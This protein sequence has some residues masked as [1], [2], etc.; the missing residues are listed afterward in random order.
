[1]FNMNVIHVPAAL[2]DQVGRAGNDLPRRRFAPIL[3]AWAVD[4]GRPQ[5]YGFR[6][7]SPIADNLLGSGLVLR[8]VRPRR[9]FQWR[10]LDEDAFWPEAMDNGAAEIYE[11]TDAGALRGCKGVCEPLHGCRPIAG[12][13]VKHSIGAF[14]NVLQSRRVP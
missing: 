5:D 12:D 7:A 9:R 14:E 1:M 13:T 3:A 2:I 10:T 4:D 11:T 8:V 6:R